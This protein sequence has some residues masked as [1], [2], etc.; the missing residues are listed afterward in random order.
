MNEMVISLI[1]NNTGNNMKY[2][3]H[4]L[5]EKLAWTPHVK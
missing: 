5:R 2:G 4:P 1:K 3:M